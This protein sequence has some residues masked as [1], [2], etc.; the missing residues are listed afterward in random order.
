MWKLYSSYANGVAIQTTIR[1]FHESLSLGDDKHRL[2]SRPVTYSDEPHVQDYNTYGVSMGIREASKIVLR[3]R[4]CYQFENEWR[5]FILDR[6]CA[7]AG[8]AVPI[9]LA[10]LIEKVWL[11]PLADAT[12]D[13]TAK[14]ITQRYGLHV[15][16]SRSMLEE[17]RSFP[18]SPIAYD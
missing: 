3:K 17:P 18:D 11:A 10:K 14:G 4:T 16:V 12:L 6:H 9:D 5:A 8:K 7:F 1:R 2:R 15:E 13:A